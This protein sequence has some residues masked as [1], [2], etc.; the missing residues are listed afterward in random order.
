ML[1]SSSKKLETIVGKDSEFRGE[2]SVAGT[3]RI[4]GTL[5]GNVRADWVVVGETGR[6]KGNIRSKGTVAGGSVEGNIDAEEII[7]LK[8]GSN[9]CGEIR[10][11]KLI[12]SEGAVFD[13]IARMSRREREADAEGEIVFINT[14]AHP[15]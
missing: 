8:P 12:I 5:E 11:G 9:V 14:P 3:V 15:S 4:D 13:G 1:G 2:M 10:S 7:E 6:I